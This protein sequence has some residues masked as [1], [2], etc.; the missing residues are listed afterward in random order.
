MDIAFV[1]MI[2]SSLKRKDECMPFKKIP[3]T[4][5]ELAKIKANPFTAKVSPSG[6]VSFTVEF[7]EF[8]YQQWL[9]GTKTS[10]IFEMAGYEQLFS[11][12]NMSKYIGRI[13]K[14]AQSPE[15]FKDITKSK[16]FKDKQFEKM[17]YEK[18]IKELQD[19]IVYLEQEIDFLK[20]ITA[21]NNKE[22]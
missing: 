21:L 22:K 1:D 8:A 20:K 16:S 17:K 7:K 18:A 13:R 6:A 3:F 9:L 11:S 14:E 4:D 2:Y 12:N 15:G 10:K 19:H 5:I